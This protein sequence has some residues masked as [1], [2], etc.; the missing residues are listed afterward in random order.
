MFCAEIPEIRCVCP[1]VTLAGR[2]HYL[3]RFGTPAS[4]AEY[5]RL[6]GEFLANGRRPPD[7][8]EPGS[9]D[10]SVNE[11]LLG[12]L[13]H[14]DRYYRKHSRPTTEPRH[15]RLAVRP[16]RRLYGTTA[17]IAVGPRALKAVRA[18]M[19]A[20]GLRRT[21]V[22]KRV[23]RV[24]RAFRWAAEEE[25]V[26]A[27]VYQSLKA[28]RGLSRG[29]C[30]ARESEPVTP[31]PD[32]AVDAIRPFVARQVWAMVEL[33]RLTGMRPGEV[34]AMR[35]VDVDRMAPTWVYTPASHKTEHH[36]RRRCIP[37]GPRAREVLRP[38]LRGDP[39]AYLFSPREAVEE[40]RAEMRRLRKT[41]V[42]PSQR[43]R[44]KANPRRVPGERYDVPAY[45]RAIEYGCR[46]AGIAKWHPNQL[47]HNAATRLRR[48]FGLDVARAVLG[49]SSVA[50][51]EV[52]TQLDEARATEAME[53][54]G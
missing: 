38:W 26:P 4:H 9:T 36:G 12:Y 19:V 15:I 37:L 46:K 49:H 40:R 8:S 53:R 34:T 44:S 43:D 29:W 28:A 51:T 5:A 39:N 2:D 52:Y 41:P 23:G 48:E 25:L 7:E 20:S 31:V 10:L 22:N 35:T 45:N 42:Q 30:D 47:Q 16:L 54:V 1:V 33:Q 18:E 3:G 13:E 50:M 14:V 6:V 24:V 21:E 17:A 11:M 27:S 32:E